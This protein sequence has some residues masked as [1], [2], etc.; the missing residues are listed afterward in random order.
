MVRSM[1]IVKW[2]VFSIVYHVYE[3]Y[4]FAFISLEK[5]VI[6]H[7]GFRIKYA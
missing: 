1:I 2:G 4:I 7:S 5:Q 3:K 6:L